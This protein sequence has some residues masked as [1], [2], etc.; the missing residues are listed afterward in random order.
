MDV[1][2]PDGTMIQNVPDGTTRS[3]LQA[4]L[5]KMPAMGPKD[6]PDQGTHTAAPEDAGPGAKV[7][8]LLEGGANA[9]T[10]A[11]GFAGGALGGIAG[12]VAAGKLGSPEG[13]SEAI[14]TAQE[15]A[16]KMQFFGPA[17]Q[18]ASEYLDMVSKAIEISK[19]QGLNPTQALT[20][21]SAPT[22]G[23]TGTLSAKPVP[24]AVVSAAKAG[25]KLTP[26][27]A[28]AGPIGRTAASLAGEPKLA[29]L[30]S[31][32]NE[33]IF[34]AKIAADLELPEG[35]ALTV[36][37]MK[38]VRQQ[39]G[40]AY[41]AVRQT[42]RVATDEEYAAALDKLGER[43][44]SAAADFPD[45]AKPDVEKVING[46]K[47]KDFGAN[48]GVDMIR[49][50]RENADQAFRAGDSGLGHVLKGGADA[51][52]K[53]LERH[54]E[55]TGQNPALVADFK[56]ARALIA[57]SY[58]AEKA[59]VGETGNINPQVY[60]AQLRKGKPLEGGAKEVA[61]FAGSFPRSAQKPV[62]T[63]SAGSWGDILIAELGKEWPLI[64][65]RPGARSLM[66]SGPYQKLQASQPSASMTAPSSSMLLAPQ[67]LRPSDNTNQTIDRLS[68]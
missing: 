12:Q 63:G 51:I 7:E 33:P 17:K 47:R 65:A 3:S 13:A 23:M 53:Q 27:E 37:T 45:L 49:Q 22:K 38:Q 55:A 19:V 25:L 24:P 29:K 61:Q 68:Q 11:V 67:V 2:M 4:R 14:R 60:A 26:E 42:G 31:K 9:L 54:L 64:F 52:E 10:G 36:D 30:I 34:N 48:A 43:F 50:L 39:A 46:L 58:T 59:L 28:G 5:A 44:R 62:N 20:M 16:Q 15:G 40:K 57:K 66:A 18:S 41:E 1:R 21:A 6:I 8:A 35:T 32:K 56:K